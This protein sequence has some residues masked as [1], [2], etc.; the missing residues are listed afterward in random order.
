MINYNNN[1]VMDSKEQPAAFAFGTEEDTATHPTR[2]RFQ[3][4]P[5][6]RRPR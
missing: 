5:A 4:A 3:R 6:S 2:Y 1:Q